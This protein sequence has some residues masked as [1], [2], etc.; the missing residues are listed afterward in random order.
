M[1]RQ[2]FIKKGKLVIFSVYDVFS[3]T[4]ILSANINKKRIEENRDLT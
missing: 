4:R 3:Y 2:K 1:Y